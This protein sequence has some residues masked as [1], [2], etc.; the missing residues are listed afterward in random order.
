MWA[1]VKDGSVSEYIETP[2]QIK[3]DS[4]VTHPQQIFERWSDAELIAVGVYPVVVSRAAVDPIYQTQG[5]DVVTINA[6]NVTITAAANNMD[7]A[8]VKAN[9]LANVRARAGDLLA[10][11]DWYIV[12]KAETSVAVPVDVTGARALVRNTCNDAETAIN[13]AADGA[14]IS[15]AVAAINWP[16]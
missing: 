9:Q 11:T 3:D 16:D 8:V 2:R 7:L 4:G 10:Q 1:L 15:A 13:D 14:A 12:R 6:D 5:D